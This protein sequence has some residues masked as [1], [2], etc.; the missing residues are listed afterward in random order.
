MASIGST[1]FVNNGTISSYIAYCGLTRI[2]TVSRRY[3]RKMGNALHLPFMWLICHAFCISSNTYR[4]LCFSLF[5][6]EDSKV[7]ML[8]KWTSAQLLDR[9]YLFPNSLWNGLVYPPCI[10]ALGQN[11]VCTR[12]RNT[13]PLSLMYRRKG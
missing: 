10:T 1:G 3:S 5:I 11:L 4:E 2:P 9:F 8:F 12:I 7:D 6:L 13:R